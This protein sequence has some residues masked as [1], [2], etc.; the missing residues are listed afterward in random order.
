MLSTSWKSPLFLS[1][2]FKAL[3]FSL[4]K[5]KLD[6]IVDLLNGLINWMIVQMNERLMIDSNLRHL[7]LLKKLLLVFG[8]AYSFEYSR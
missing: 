3:V 7:L 2:N 8:V 6:D 4:L 1:Q 5:D